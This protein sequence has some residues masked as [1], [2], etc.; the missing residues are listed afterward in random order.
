MDGL[1]D[2]APAE[3]VEESAPAPAAA[4]E[5]PSTPVAATV[6]TFQNE[7]LGSDVPVVVDFWATWCGPCRAVAPILD[8]LAEEYQGRL[9]VVKVDTD[10]NP[11]LAMAYGVTSIP[12]MNFFKGGEV[13]KSV[14]GAR[15]KP[16]LT[17]LFDEV[18]S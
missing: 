4:A 14:V 13:V 17:Q 15:P 9:K 5:L 18:L 7:V 11:Q 3:V 6:D 8:E 2:A 12:T 10:E 1:A 16:A